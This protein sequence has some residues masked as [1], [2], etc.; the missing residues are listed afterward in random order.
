MTDIECI[1]DAKANVGESPFW[2][3]EEQRV[4]WV[5]IAGKAMHRT[6]PATG[7]DE[8]WLHEDMAGCIALR[9]SGGILAAMQLGFYRFDPTDASWTHLHDPEPDMPGNRFNDG[10]C[11]TAGRFWAGTMRIDGGNPG[12]DGALYRLDPDGTCTRMQT[13]YWTVNGLAFSPDGRTMYVSD[14]NPQVRTIW[15]YDYDP[16]TGLPSNKRLFFD[17][18]GRPGRPDGGAMDSDGCYWMAGVS[19]WELVRFTPKGKVDRVIEMP[20]EK[21]SKIAFGGPGLDVMFVTSISDG[22]TPGSEDKQPKAGGL[23]AVHAGVTGLPER[24]YGG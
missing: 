19:G 3:G 23:F 16:Q 6:D 21:P 2:H 20:V 14:S 17:T 18:H 22:L 24:T 5:D 8:V 12:P 1:V 10:A 15:V 9:E 4:Y 7:Q 11:D 13:G